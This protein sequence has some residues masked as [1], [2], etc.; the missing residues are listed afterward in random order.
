MF[1][2][3]RQN[4]RCVTPVLCQVSTSHDLSFSSAH[5]CEHSEEVVESA[6]VIA[7]HSEYSPAPIAM[8]D[9]LNAEAMSQSGSKMEKWN[10]L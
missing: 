1:Q 3:L 10:A 7:F 9:I 8:D 6:W 2:K 5:R 4:S